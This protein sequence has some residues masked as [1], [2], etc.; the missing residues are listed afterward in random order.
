MNFKNLPTFLQILQYTF[1]LSPDK[2][3]EMSSVL[4]KSNFSK[5]A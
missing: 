2:M 1:D 3:N 4:T 5:L